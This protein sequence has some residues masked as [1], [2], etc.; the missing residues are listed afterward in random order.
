MSIDAKDIKDK[1][2]RRFWESGG[3]DTRG[4]PPAHIA[5]LELILVHLD[6]ACSLQDVAEGVGRQKDHH[7]LKGYNPPR[8]A[9]SV[10]GNFRLEYSCTDNG[11]ITIF[12]YGDYH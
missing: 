2:I 12:F 4:L 9:M 10:N 5:A 11:Q 1:R 8:Y 7:K 3:T 6:S